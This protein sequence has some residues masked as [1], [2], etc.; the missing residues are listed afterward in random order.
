MYYLYMG[1]IYGCKV[2][3]L[4]IINIRNILNSMICIDFMVK[5]YNFK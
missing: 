3:I 2:I 5:F 1:V 4:D